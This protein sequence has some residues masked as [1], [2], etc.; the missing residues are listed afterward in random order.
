MLAAH[1]EPTSRHTL[2]REAPLP[3]ARSQSPAQ[4]VDRVGSVD[5]EEGDFLHVPPEDRTGYLP[6]VCILQAPPRI[7]HAAFHPCA[8][9]AH[10]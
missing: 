8:T 6:P 9:A 7:A 5:L 4:G 2:Q 1:R 10:S 3:T